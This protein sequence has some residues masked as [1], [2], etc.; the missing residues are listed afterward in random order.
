MTFLQRRE[1]TPNFG[2]IIW[3][4]PKSIAQI[5]LQKTGAS[6]QWTRY[7]VPEVRA[8]VALKTEDRDHPSYANGGIIGLGEALGPPKTAMG[9]YAFL[10]LT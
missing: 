3:G 6:G 1:Q 2:S 5:L 7:L 8:E 9:G 10:P 4:P